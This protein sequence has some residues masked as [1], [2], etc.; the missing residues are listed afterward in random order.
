MIDS[1][2]AAGVVIQNLNGTRIAVSQE[3]AEK[4][5][6]I[7]VDFPESPVRRHIENCDII[8]D[9]SD[10]NIIILGAIP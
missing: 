9:G 10:S 3:K 5:V 4:N 6:R 8:N 7:H 2:C 1:A